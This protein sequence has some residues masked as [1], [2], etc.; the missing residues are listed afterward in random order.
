[1]MV[2]MAVLVA[3]VFLAAVVGMRVRVRVNMTR[4]VRVLASG[5]GVDHLSEE[6]NHQ[7]G[8]NQGVT[9]ET[10]HVPRSVPSKGASRTR[11]LF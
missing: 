10:S 9:A 6:L 4:Q 3:A 2:A 1:M 5:P 8:G 7:I 11:P